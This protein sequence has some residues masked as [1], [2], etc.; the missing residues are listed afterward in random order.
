[1]LP[2]ILV[3]S[4]LAGHAF[5]LPAPVRTLDKRIPAAVYGA[6]GFEVKAQGTP[7]VVL[8][9]GISVNFQNTDSNF[10]VYKDGIAQWDSQV[11]QPAGCD[12][13]DC[14][15]AF[16]SDGN[17]VSYFNG[18]PTWFTGTGGGQ[19]AWLDFF[20]VEPYIVIYNAAFQPIYHTP[21]TPPPP[22]P[23]PPPPSP[24]PV[25]THPAKPPTAPV[26]KPPPAPAGTKPGP[27]SKN[28]DGDPDGDPPSDNP[29][30]DDPPSDDPPSD[31]PPSDDP[32]ID[33]P[34]IDDPP[35]DDGTDS[36]G[37][38]DS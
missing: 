33:D 36:G 24:G 18:V 37:D 22:P 25:P 20:D 15:L 4:F 28:P 29:P 12:T 35:I 1:M 8:D 10:V 9:D 23:P 6:G 30:S 17:L 2:K 32:P 7:I 19:G 14:V 31:D 34:P 11:H 13:N 21:I 38:D 3:L 27:S 16:Q 26:I 5:P